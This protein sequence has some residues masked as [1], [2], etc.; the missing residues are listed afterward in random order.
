MGFDITKTAVFEDAMHGVSSAKNAGFYVVAVYDT[1]S[2]A[3][4]DK[5]KD[6]ADVHIY[7]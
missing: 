7:S 5:I 6:L 4:W 2:Q 3:D 1:A